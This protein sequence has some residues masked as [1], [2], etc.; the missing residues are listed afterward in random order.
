MKQR[1][2]II[3]NSYSLYEA[4]VVDALSSCFRADLFNEAFCFRQ[5]HWYYIVVV[6]K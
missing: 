4:G 1:I 2:N 5:K 6:Y 3:N